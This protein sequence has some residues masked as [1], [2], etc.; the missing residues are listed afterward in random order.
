MKE[1]AMN[2]PMLFLLASACVGTDVAADILHEQ[3]SR[4]VAEASL[5]AIMGSPGSSRCDPIETEAWKKTGIEFG[6][7]VDRLLRRATLPPGWELRRGDHSMWN[8]LV[9]DKGRTRA[10][11]FYKAAFWDEDAFIRLQPRFVIR[12][13]A[14]HEREGPRSSKIRHMVMDADREVFATEVVLI[15]IRGDDRKD[16][17]ARVEALEEAQNDACKQWLCQRYPN[18]ERV[19]AHWDE[20]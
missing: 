18:Y 8:Y 14:E 1:N 12:R 15:E 7:P 6:E 10:S 9:D 4:L 20:A 5:L 17:Y 3:G 19:D 2:D 16:F 11:Q 13:E